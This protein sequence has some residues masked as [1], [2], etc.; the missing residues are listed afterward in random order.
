MA[1]LPF[2]FRRTGISPSS[3]AATDF[4]GRVVVRLWAAGRATKARSVWARQLSSKKDHR[5]DVQSSADAPWSLPAD[6]LHVMCEVVETAGGLFLHLDRADPD[7]T[8]YDSAIS[9]GLSLADLVLGPGGPPRLCV[10]Q[11]LILP[12]SR[13]LPSDRHAAGLMRRAAAELFELGVPAV[14]VIPCVTEAL[15]AEVIEPLAAAVAEASSRGTEALLF[16]TRKIQLAIAA[17]TNN[18]DTLE[19]AFDVC[20]YCVANLALSTKAS[21]PVGEAKTHGSDEIPQGTVAS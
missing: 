14:L 10:L 13:R 18:A 15:A 1:R 5:F 12:E 8:A 11:G 3:D 7:K 21:T 6:V 4:A 20:L 16:A 17:G 2:M 9:P 19:I